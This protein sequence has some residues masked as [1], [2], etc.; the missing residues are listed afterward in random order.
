MVRWAPL[1][2]HLRDDGLDRIKLT[3]AEIEAIVGGSLPD[4]AIKYRPVYWANSGGGI[5]HHWLDAGYRT[6]YAACR[7]M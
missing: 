2:R 7:A 5:G 3:Y 6:R 4:S 1:T